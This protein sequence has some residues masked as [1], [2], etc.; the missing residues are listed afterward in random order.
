MQRHQPAYQQLLTH[1]WSD[2][3]AV[4]TSASTVPTDYTNRAL[5][6]GVRFSGEERLRLEGFEGGGLNLAPTIPIC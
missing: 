3:G 4:K 6:H 5:P 2:A 1:P